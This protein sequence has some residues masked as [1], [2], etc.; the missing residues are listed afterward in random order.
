MNELDKEG[1]ISYRLYRQHTV[2]LGN[3]YVKDLSMIGRD[4]TKTLI[5]D[6][7]KE[8]FRNQP[9][10]GIHIRDFLGEEDDEELEYLASDLKG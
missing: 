4:L 3:G 2:Q 5:V 10:N 7:L 9:K 6:N 8:N 1:Y